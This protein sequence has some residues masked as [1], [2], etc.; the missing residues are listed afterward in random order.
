[1][2]DEAPPTRPVP[3]A[4]MPV[5]GEVLMD[6][7][8]VSKFVGTGGMASVL[9]ARHVTLGTEVAIKVLDPTLIHDAEAK[10]RFARESRAMATLTSKHAVRVFDVGSLPS[11]LPFMVMELLEGRDLGRELNDRGPL[12]LEEAVSYI[13]QA[14]QAVAEAHQQGIIHR[15]LKPQNLFLTK[16]KGQPIIRVLDFGIARLMGTEKLDTITRLGDV[17]GT[18][19]YMAP[20]QIR[21]SR[22]VDARSD[23]WSLGA[24]LYKLITG[25]PP[26]SMQGEAPLMSAI[27]T[28]PPKPIG[29]YRK[30][31]PAVLSSVILRCLRKPPE[32]RFQSAN[33]LR[34]ALDEARALMVTDEL[35]F[36]TEVMPNLREAIRQHES[37]TNPAHKETQRAGSDPNLLAPAKFSKTVPLSSPEAQ[38]ARAMIAQL[39]PQNSQPPSQPRI[40]TDRVSMPSAVSSRAPAPRAPASSALSFVMIIL[41]VAIGVF[42]AGLGLLYVLSRRH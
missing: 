25:H 15:D 16:V 34:K 37:G 8:R 29:E 9:A 22:T 3:K 24:C 11:G 2:S 18:L 27:L 36:K 31:V 28:A 14:A 30:D 21:S 19:H 17:I 10:E 33:D 38:A 7:Y 20:E 26:W 13:D 32:E 40:S 42:I 23:I 6:R 35:Q 39:P 1:M 4:T 5:V 12:P 41:A